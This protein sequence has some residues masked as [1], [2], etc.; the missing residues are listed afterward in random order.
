MNSVQH[1]LYISCV[2]K[3]YIWWWQWPRKRLTKRQRQRWCASK[4]QHILYFWQAGNLRTSNMAFPPNFSTS[5]TKFV[6]KKVPPGILHLVFGPNK[7]H[8]KF[9]PNIFHYYWFSTCSTSSLNIW[10]SHSLGKAGCKK[11]DVK[12][13]FFCQTWGTSNPNSLPQQQLGAIE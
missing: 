12:S 13:L 9:L 7:F 8:Q 6:T 1:P 4:T 3:V 10:N 2:A 11:K 5:S